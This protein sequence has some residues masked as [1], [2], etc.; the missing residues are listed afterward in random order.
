M[1]RYTQFSSSSLMLSN[2]AEKAIQRSCLTKTGFGRTAFEKRRR[3]SRA[4]AA[5]DTF[6]I[7]EIRTWSFECWN[8]LWGMPFP[9]TYMA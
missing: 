5:V 6:G 4:Q 1:D 3:F 2:V 8:E 9:G 7:E